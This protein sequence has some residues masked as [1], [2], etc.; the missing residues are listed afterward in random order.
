MAKNKKVNKDELD[1]LLESEHFLKTVH[2]KTKYRIVETLVDKYQYKKLDG[3]DII[4]DIADDILKTLSIVGAD[5]Y[6]RYGRYGKG[7]DETN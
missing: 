1:E 6:G 4:E 3:L 2:M 7:I 5:M